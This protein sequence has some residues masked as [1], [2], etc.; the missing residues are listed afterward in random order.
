VYGDGDPPEPTHEAG[1]DW[2]SQLSSGQ[3][4]RISVA[5]AEDDPPDDPVDG[6]AAA[7]PDAPPDGSAVAL[8]DGGAGRQRRIRS[9]RLGLGRGTRVG[10]GTAGGTSVCG[11]RG[12][13]RRCRT[14]RTPGHHGYHAEQTRD[15]GG[16][17]TLADSTLTG[18]TPSVGTSDG[19]RADRRGPRDGHGG[20]GH[21]GRRVTSHGSIM[22]PPSPGD[23]TSATPEIAPEVVPDV[24]AQPGTDH[25]LHE[26]GGPGG[27]VG[28]GVGPRSGW[29]GGMVSS[30]ECAVE[31]GCPRI[32]D[33]GQD[34]GGH[35]DGGHSLTG[36]GR[37]ARAAPRKMVGSSAG[38]TSGRVAG[39]PTDAGG[40]GV[41]APAETKAWK[42][43]FSISAAEWR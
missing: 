19:Q 14:R 34:G 33:P 21:L 37:S 38:V 29:P 42:P 32:V 26:L 40:L 16:D 17:G 43:S 6:S 28:R 4:Y 23:A 5:L 3:M 41:L 15:N 24:T 35:I 10:L 20:G 18:G 25:V 39:V 1:S 8:P 27:D 11:R 12:R 22:R 9:R 13:R 7:P 2:I 31:T 36:R 30:S